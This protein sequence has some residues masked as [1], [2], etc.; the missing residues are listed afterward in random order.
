MGEVRSSS[1]EKKMRKMR[2]IGKYSRHVG[3]NSIKKKNENTEH[4]TKKR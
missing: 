4:N 1:H 2:K 3:S